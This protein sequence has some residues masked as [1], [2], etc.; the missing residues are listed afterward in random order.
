M[1]T[2]GEK[3]GQD[4]VSDN[5]SDLPAKCRTR[6]WIVTLFFATGIVGV[7]N[8]YLLSDADSGRQATTSGVAFSL[9]TIFCL[10]AFI[11]LAPFAYW[12]VLVP[13]RWD[14][15]HCRKRLNGRMSWQCQSCDEEIHKFSFLFR[16]GNLDCLKQPTSFQ[17]PHCGG[18]TYLTEGRDS[19]LP[20]L[21]LDRP[22][23]PVPPSAEERRADK[24]LQLEDYEFQIKEL[25]YKLAI[26][27][28][29][30]ELN[31]APRPDP[32]QVR[33]DAAL[34]QMDSII[35]VCKT[36]AQSFM[37]EQSLEKWID[38]QSLDDRGKSDLKKIVNLSFE[39]FRLGHR[40]QT[41]GAIPLAD[42]STYSESNEKT[43]I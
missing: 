39:H 17:C 7:L 36:S 29:E 42:E 4:T 9:V 41:I 11:I 2:D 31:P 6:I 37:E 30:S 27:Q 33:I 18:L 34:R 12:Y 16:C 1:V 5:H 38:D 13:I 8:W 19:R 24:T 26:G 23:S 3:D 35:Q 21:A 20:A 14:C 22:T 28:L 15:P 10:I 40:A 43:I 25:R 32:R